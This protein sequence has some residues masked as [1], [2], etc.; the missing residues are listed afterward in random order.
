M[1]WRH[2]C[3]QAVSGAADRDKFNIVKTQHYL[4]GCEHNSETRCTPLKPT[5][6]VTMF[7]IVQ[8]QY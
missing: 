4:A 6:V 2:H 5:M 7:F 1:P 8:T 3:Q